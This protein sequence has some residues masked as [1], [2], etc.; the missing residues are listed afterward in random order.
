MFASLYKVILPVTDVD[1]AEAFYSRLLGVSGRRVSADRH[2]FD[3]GGM[4]LSCLLAE[5]EGSGSPVAGET[6]WFA[7][8]DLD[9]AFQQAAKAGGA[10]ADS[11]I[12]T[13]PW[14]DRLFVGE[15]PF[16]NTVGFVDR[17]TMERQKGETQRGGPEDRLSLGLVMSVRSAQGSGEN[18]LGASVCRI[19]KNEIWLQFVEPP[20]AIFKEKDAVQVQYYE[21]RAAIVAYTDVV[22]L[23]ESDEHFLA[24]SMPDT[25]EL[26]QRRAAPRVATSV[27]VHFT[28]TASEED[29]SRVSAR[30][31]ES[32]TRDIS[33]GGM[34]FETESL[35]GTGDMLSL[36]LILS[37][38]EEVSVTARVTTSRPI[39]GQD[40]TANSVGIQFVEM[41]L[42]DQ[43]QLLEYLIA[44]EEG[45]DEP[46]ST[47]SSPTQ[48]PPEPAS[49]PTS[50]E[51]PAREGA[52]TSDPVVS[53]TM[54]EISLP[55][56]GSGQEAAVPV[57]AGVLD[58]EP[59]L[60]PVVQA[61]PT[62][63]SGQLFLEL[64]NGFRDQVQ[65]NSVSVA[66][67][68][69]SRVELLSEPAR[70]DPGGR[71]RVEV[72]QGLL[73]LFDSQS[74]AAQERKIQVV[75]ALHP[76]PPTQPGPSLYHVKFAGQNFTHFS[77]GV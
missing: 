54:G 43:I 20:G 76:E 48:S 31:V 10:M 27:P 55:E 37:P 50:E 72:T 39:V 32:E 9:A 2:E 42:D 44:R 6:V 35:L 40:Q 57:L 13:H 28:V 22:Q 56:V 5:G 64:A 69:R 21:D 3:C 7:V 74:G 63:E 18:R 16:K 15:D 4:T 34:R 11:Q 52:A 68:A 24:I 19:F 45:E 1:Q 12:V 47:S 33:T 25:L 73:E 62:L 59:G 70:L 30:E 71:Q 53:E 49:L 23:S 26:L 8:G 65:V 41:Q 61:L 75:L 17:T 60:P 66:K 36:R 77:G 67:G 46:V 58:E 51:L 14:G 29:E 38:T